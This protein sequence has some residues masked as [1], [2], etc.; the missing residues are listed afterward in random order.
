MTESSRRK[1]GGSGSQV[2]AERGYCLCLGKLEGKWSVITEMGEGLGDK[3]VGTVTQGQAKL[4][5]TNSCRLSLVGEY[6][7][8]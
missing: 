4:G 6:F 2:A 8:V 7:R 5:H 1:A 3:V